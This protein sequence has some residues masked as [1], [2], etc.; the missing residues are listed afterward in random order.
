MKK[1]VLLSLIFMSS[2]VGFIKH[3]L[4]IGHSFCRQRFSFFRS[5]MDQWAEAGNFRKIISFYTQDRISS[6]VFSCCLK[7]KK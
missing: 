3:N 4:A 5:N 6:Q 7:Y 2:Q 1:L